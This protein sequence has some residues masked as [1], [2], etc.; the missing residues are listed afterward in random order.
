MA[1]PLV[2][3]GTLNRLRASVVVPQAPELNVTA[4]YLGKEG[5]SLALEGETTLYIPTMTGAV[6][7]AEPYQMCSVSVNLLK[8]Q[9]VANLYKQRMELLS[10]IGD[11]V[12]RPDASALGDYQI[13]NCAIRSVAELN[14]SGQDAGF[15]VTLG[16][17]YNVNSLTFLQA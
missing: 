10:T 2:T 6:T 11:I 5:I 4:A 12:V 3:Q 16:G 15:R 14:M 1:N 13:F 7:S 8:T 17:Y 9:F